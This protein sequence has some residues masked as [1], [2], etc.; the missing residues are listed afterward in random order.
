MDFA[1][2]L[3]I[4]NFF[5]TVFMV[6][7]IWMVQVVHYPLF[8]EVGEENSI[9]YHKRHQTLVTFVVGPPMLVELFSSIL[10]A[11]YPPA[12]VDTWLIFAGIGLVF[13]IW[14]STAALQVPCHGKLVEGFDEKV[15]RSLVRANWIRTL[16]WTAR[17]LLVAWMIAV[18]LAA[19]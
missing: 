11:W 5:A 4:V 7:L 13:V 19:V 2:L 12:S 15:H 17:G 18:V 14:L 1:T 16:A 9:T 10:L 3:L 6:G 8:A